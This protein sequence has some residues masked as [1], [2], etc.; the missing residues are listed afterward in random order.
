MGEM[1]WGWTGWGCIWRAAWSTVDRSWCLP[2]LRPGVSV[3][4]AVTVL[5]GGC[6][7]CTGVKLGIREGK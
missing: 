6:T 4:G 1:D 7:S 3:M 2:R 5:V